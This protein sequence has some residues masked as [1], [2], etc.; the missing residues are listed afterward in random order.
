MIIAGYDSY[1]D[2]TLAS[3][4]AHSTDGGLSWMSDRFAGPGAPR[5]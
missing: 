2:S 3:G 4:Y 1:E 5:S